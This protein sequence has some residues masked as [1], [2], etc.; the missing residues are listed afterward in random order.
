LNANNICELD[1]LAGILLYQ[2]A[3]G[4][5]FSGDVLAPD[6]IRML[7]GDFTYPSIQA[8]SPFINE[9][10]IV[11]PDVDDAVNGVVHVIDAVL[12]L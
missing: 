3:H 11:I 7:N 6:Q 9:S 5:R 10:Q 8:G 4:E 2:V 1:G 12:P